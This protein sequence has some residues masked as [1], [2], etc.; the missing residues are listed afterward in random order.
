MDEFALSLS[1][2]Q[3]TWGD[4]CHELNIV[5]SCPVCLYRHFRWGSNSLSL[6]NYY[7][8]TC[9]LCYIVSTWEWH[10]IQ[11]L[12]MLWSIFIKLKK[13]KSVTVLISDKCF[14]KAWKTTLRRFMIL[15]TFAY[16]MGIATRWSSITFMGTKTK[17]KALFFCIRVATS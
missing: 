10:S 8:N 4:L 6:V 9:P 1:G 3:K 14:L 17:W 11:I 13:A 15:R 16:N 12:L 7:N 5:W 2:K